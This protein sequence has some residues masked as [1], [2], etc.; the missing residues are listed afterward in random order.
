MNEE[1][2]AANGPDDTKEY[3]NQ[4]N[5]RTEEE[6]IKGACQDDQLEAL[7]ACARKDHEERPDKKPIGSPPLKDSDLDNGEQPAEQGNAN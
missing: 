6:I 7:K 2:T 4:P 3:Q 5:Q 1:N